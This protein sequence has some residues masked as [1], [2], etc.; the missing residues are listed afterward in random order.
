MRVILNGKKVGRGFETEY[1]F[2]N[3]AFFTKKGVNSENALREFI[4]SCYSPTDDGKTCGVCSK[5]IRL[6]EENRMV[7]EIDYKINKRFFT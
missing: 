1:F 7:K 5:C 3:K 4:I 6:R 2:S